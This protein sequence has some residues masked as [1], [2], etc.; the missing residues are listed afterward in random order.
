MIFHRRV[1]HSPILSPFVLLL[2][3]SLLFRRKVVD[4]VEELADLFGGL[5]LDHVCYRLAADIEKRLDV[6]VVGSQDDLEEHLL[7]NCDELLVPLADISGALARLI[8]VLI[9]VG[10]RERLATV[11]LA[12][13]QNLL[14]HARRDIGKGN[15]LIALA[16][17]L[18]HVLDK[19]G[20]LNDLLVGGKLLVVGRDE[21]NHGEKCGKNE[22]VAGKVEVRLKE[23]ILG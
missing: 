15:G 12:V 3:L 16:D 18:K 17:V 1:T 4:D 13:L 19:N 2:D 8:L 10:T 5:A 6:E 9:G 7:I 22:G 23:R 20:A 11:V 21:E 14:Q